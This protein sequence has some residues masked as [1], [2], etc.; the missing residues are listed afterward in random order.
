MYLVTS[1]KYLVTGKKYL[2]IPKCRAE[3]FLAVLIFAVLIFML[4]KQ[5]VFQAVLIFAYLIE[6]YN[7]LKRYNDE[8]ND[9][10][11]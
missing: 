9:E 4:E 11:K 1:K 7:L 3:F 8:V 2:T 10:E 5:I 6:N